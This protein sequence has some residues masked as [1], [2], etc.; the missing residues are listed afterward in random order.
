MDIKNL[1]KE[2]FNFNAENIEILGEGYDSKAFLIN[3]EYVF[4]IKMSTNNK[5]GYEKE[6]AVSA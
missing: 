5:K 6:K 2:K 3:K 1:V 4:K